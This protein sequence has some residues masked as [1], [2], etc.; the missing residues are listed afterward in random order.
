M[1]A[2]E[3]AKYGKYVNNRFRVRMSSS[4]YPAQCTGFTYIDV[5]LD[6]GNWSSYR[7]LGSTKEWL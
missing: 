1:I 3:V 2:G 6:V 7:E 5:P 4:G